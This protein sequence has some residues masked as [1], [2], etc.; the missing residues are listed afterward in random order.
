MKRLLTGVLGVLVAVGVALP[1]S[2][3]QA[4]D[5]GGKLADIAIDHVGLVVRDVDAVAKAYADVFGVPVPAVQ[6]ETGIQFPADFTGDRDASVKTAL[7]A[8]NGVSVELIQPVGGASPWRDHLDKYGEGMHHISYHGLQ[9]AYAQASKAIEKGGKV[10]VGGPGATTVMVDLRE[11]LGMTIGF[12]ELPVNPARQAPA[13]AAV[14]ADNVVSYTSVVVPETNE[15]VAL[16]AEITGAA[17]PTV[18]EAR[19]SYPEGYTGE[20]TGH[21]TL[22]MVA[23]NGMGLAF[24][25][26]MGGKSP[27]RE[28]VDQNGPALHHFGILIKGHPQQIEYLE[29]KGGSIVI[30]GGTMGYSWM[31]LSSTLKTLIEMNGQ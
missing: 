30:G 22:G 12:S 3:E 31:D 27:W 10:V 25:A 14:F 7:I 6:E 2:A 11:Q 24:T 29:G 17:V 20:W 13:E 5:A 16:F 4:P 19:I 9:D 28:S 21:P 15:A 1:L 26:P 8:L 23:L 18:I